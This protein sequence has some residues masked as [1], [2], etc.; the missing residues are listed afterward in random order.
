[1]SGVSLALLDGVPLTAGDP[2]WRIGRREGSTMIEE[3]P[4]KD[5]ALYRLAGGSVWPSS[6]GSNHR[7]PP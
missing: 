1:V 2:R 5:D 7:A 6:G 4:L 3:R